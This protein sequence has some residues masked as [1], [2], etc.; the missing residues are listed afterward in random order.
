MLLAW[1]LKQKDIKIHYE[2]SNW[3]VLRLD[4]APAL[5][6]NTRLY[7]KNE[8]KKNGLTY[9]AAAM[10]TKANSFLIL[11]PEFFRISRLTSKWWFSSGLSFWGRCYKTFFAVKWFVF[12]EKLPWLNYRHTNGLQA[13]IW[14]N[15]QIKWSE[16]LC[17][18][19]SCGL[20]YK[21]FRIVNLWSWLMLQ[22]GASLMIVINDAS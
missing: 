21:S 14:A 5:L 8:L 2:I 7:R 6:T 10:A 3:P 20:Y 1:Q 22:F 16:C 11:A 12:S 18:E 13:V 15:S 17:V 9:F 4:K 19:S